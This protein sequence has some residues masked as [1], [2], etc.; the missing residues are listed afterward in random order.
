[1]KISAKKEVHWAFPFQP[2]DSLAFTEILPLAAPKK[3]FFHG[4]NQLIFNQSSFSN[5]ISGGQNN[6]GVIGRIRYNL[7]YRTNSH[8]W[9]NYW[10]AGYG[11]LYSQGQT[12]RKT[13]DNWSFQSNYGYHLGGNYFL[14]TGLQLMSQ[15]T[16]G[17]NY[18]ATPNP[19]FD[20]RISNFMSPGYFNLGI[21][22]SYHPSE[23]FQA[24][25]RPI[26]GKFTIVLE[27]HL[28]KA[29]NFGLERNG[30]SLRIELGAMASII[31]KWN[32]VK[33][34]NY[35]HQLQLFT[36]Y[37]QHAER[38]DI[39]YSGQL[40]FKFNKWITTNVSVDVVY[41]HDQIEKTQFKQVLGIGATYQLGW[42]N[43]EKDKR[44]ITPYLK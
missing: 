1:M 27:K 16:A 35:T 39:A 37:L 43:K 32:I 42:E 34:A 25:F 14:S 44:F 8:F 9:E 2:K 36:N 21:G 30:Q 26:N 4:S 3:W 6:V 29:G 13:E 28:Q 41:D 33:N 22:L 20:D 31:H 17:Y 38:V 18:T 40:N 19:S 11:W 7:T 24:I 15:F 23:N 5:W 10:I 12:S